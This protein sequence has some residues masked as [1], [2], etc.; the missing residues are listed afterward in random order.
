MYRSRPEGSIDREILNY[1]SSLKD[2]FAIFFY[3][4]TGSEAHV[5]M[6]HEI[7]YLSREELVEILQ[8]LEEAKNHP[9]SIMKK[10]EY[11]DV[12]ES[13]ESFVVEKIGMGNGGMLQTA[14]SRNDQVMTDLK[15]K[16]RNDINEISVLL[17]GLVESLLKS[18]DSNKDTIMLLYTHLQHAQIG[19]FSHYLLSYTEALFRDMERLEE[20]YTRINQSPLGSLAIGGSTLSVD[21]NRTASLLGFDQLS[22]NSIDATTSRDVI[23]EYLS[24]L[25]ILM[26]TLS[27]IAEDLILW[28]TDEFKYIELAD[29]VS[30]T[31]SAMPQK[32]NPDP[33]EILRSKSGGILG[34][35]T[36]SMTILKGLPSGYSRDLQELKSLVFSSTSTTESSLSILRIVIESCIVHKSRMLELAKRS[37]ANAI[38]VAEFLTSKEHLDFRSAHKL[39]GSLVRLAICNG[40][41]TLEDL[42]GKDIE[43]LLHAS[44]D[45]ISMET[46]K[47]IIVACGAENSLTLRK[48]KGSP[49]HSEQV[50]MI[51]H[52][53]MRLIN[54]RERTRKRKQAISN[55]YDELSKIVRS[56]T[57]TS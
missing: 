43:Q 44:G 41:H 50:E 15:M 47:E 42:G 57:L 32:K 51:L 18:A 54:F 24:C 33:L 52:N 22:I 48:S 13:I 5:I 23:L 26:I 7:G 31:S 38:D 37:F 39:V 53:Q 30:S 19:T 6:L 20:L 12:H 49:S 46:L 4:I 28:S 14:R 21:R 36:A 45:R 2:D 17:G 10:D 29:S 1:L 25:S 34:N 8:A 40:K 35:L 9:K 55:A 27:R 56:Y 3:D 16:V 11:E